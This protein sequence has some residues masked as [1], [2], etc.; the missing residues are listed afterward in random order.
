[1]GKFAFIVHP[2]GAGD[3]ARRFP[4]ARYLPGWLVEKAAGYA[5]PFKL[6]DIAGIE[7]SSGRAEGFKIAVPLT[8]RQMSSL[9]AISI[10]DRIFRAISLAEKLGAGVIGLGGLTPVAER[11]G[12]DPANFKIAVTSGMNYTVAISIEAIGEAAALMGYDLK[13]SSVVI[14]GAAGQVESTCA[15]MLSSRVSRMTLVDKEKGKLKELAEKV[16]YHSGLSARICR[17]AKSELQSARIV[18]AGPGAGVVGTEDFVPGSVVC[19][20]TG[21][22]LL[23]QSIAEIRDDV[24]VVEGGL[25]S[26]PGSRICHSD[27]RYP[28]GMICA[29][30]AE[31]MIMAL[32]GTAGNITGYGV[33]LEKVKK[34]ASLAD[35]HGFKM[36]GIKGHKEVITQRDVE[37]IKLTARK[38]GFS[39]AAIP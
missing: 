30:M 28:P 36:A 6:S 19:V 33:S 13:K 15:V 9:S 4:M 25:V 8:L 10:S 21:T 27:P 16:L 26:F 39:E 1:M 11:V 7:S 2:L 31:A 20:L 37:R 23:S 12:I 34:I 29:Q 38:N 5:P 32:E 17:D 35:K 18:I 22:C 24:L 3:I 14:L